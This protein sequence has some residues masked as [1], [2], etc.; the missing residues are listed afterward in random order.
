MGQ[1]KRMFEEMEINVL[2]IDMDDDL[3]QLKRNFQVS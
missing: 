2:D 3:Y 1:S